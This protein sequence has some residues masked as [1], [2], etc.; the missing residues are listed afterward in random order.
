MYRQALWNVAPE[1]AF[2]RTL[3]GSLEDQGTAEW[4][5]AAPPHR[6][7]ALFERLEQ[8][9][10][11]LPPWAILW[12]QRRVLDGGLDADRAHALLTR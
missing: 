8:A 1:R 7:P 5:G 10:A 3:A 2:E 6:R 11:P 9:M 12:L 4:F